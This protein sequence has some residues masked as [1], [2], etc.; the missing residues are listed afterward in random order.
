MQFETNEAVLSTSPST[1]E[2]GPG[3]LHA[4]NRR[5]ESCSIRTS[6]RKLWPALSSVHCVECG[7][8][9]TVVHVPLGVRVCPDCAADNSDYNAITKQDGLRLFMLSDE[10]TLDVAFFQ[11][12]KAHMYSATQPIDPGLINTAFIGRAEPTRT[13]SGDSQV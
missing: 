12:T 1:E 6:W 5:W 2:Q 9:T 13:H 8:V 7:D 4:L 11:A 10:D 3:D